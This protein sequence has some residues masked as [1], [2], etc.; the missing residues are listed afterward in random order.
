MAFKA[1]ASESAWIT[2]KISLHMAAQEL[3]CKHLNNAN[4][5]CKTIEI[6]AKGLANMA[7]IIL[8]AVHAETIS[9]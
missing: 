1:L 8:A 7:K 2:T 6:Y 5:Q 9:K 4:K 3:K